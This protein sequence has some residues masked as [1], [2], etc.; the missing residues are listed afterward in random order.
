MAVFPPAR[1]MIVPPSG[2]LSRGAGCSATA[3][4]PEFPASN[5]TDGFAHTVTR[6]DA[7][8][9]QFVVELDLADTPNVFGIIHHN[10]DRGNICLF[11]SGG[12]VLD[13]G[14]AARRPNFWL[15]LRGFPS[16]DVHWVFGVNNNSRPI[17]VG[18]IVLGIAY[19]FNGVIESEPNEDVKFWQERQTMEYGQ[20]A[21]SAVK[22][23][24]RR[25]SLTLRL[26]QAEVGY[27]EQITDEANLSGEPVVVVPDSRR[28]DIWFVHWPRRRDIRYTQ[29]AVADIDVTLD[30][31]EESAGVV[32]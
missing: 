28:N 30:L 26:N 8:T 9:N 3:V 2:L 18:E 23:A 15:D 19:E 17:M 4:D 7:H 31:V 21:I 22:A 10:I 25:M 20:L 14:A 32:L 11:Q 24:Q 5:A 27:F 12:L 6:S 1:T 16:T 13:R 29:S